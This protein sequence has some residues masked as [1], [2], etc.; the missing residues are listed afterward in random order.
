MDLNVPIITVGHPQIT[1][2]TSDSAGPVASAR[3]QVQ[4]PQPP[5]MGTN[6]LSNEVLRTMTQAM[7]NLTTQCKSEESK[8]KIRQSMV[9]IENMDGNK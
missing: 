7:S 4:H 3:S 9:E 5:R 6:E 2:I 1:T 8:N